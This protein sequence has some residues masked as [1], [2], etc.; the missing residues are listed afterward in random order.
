MFTY[1]HSTLKRE[2]ATVTR[3]A[4]RAVG[5]TVRRT[6]KSSPKRTAAHSALKAA[7]SAPIHEIAATPSAPAAAQGHCPVNAWPAEISTMKAL[8]RK[9]ARRCRYT[10]RQLIHGNRTPMV[11][12]PTVRRVC[13]IAPSIC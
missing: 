13:V 7:A 6:V 11:S 5:V 1:T 9:N 4:R 10:I 2:S 3:V 8:A 12:T